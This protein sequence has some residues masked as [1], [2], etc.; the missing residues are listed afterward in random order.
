MESQE[1]GQK[2]SE[3]E[4]E[5]ESKPITLQKW[6]DNEYP[7]KEDKEKCLQITIGWRDEFKSNLPLTEEQVK[8][9]A[10]EELDL[11][12]YPNLKKIQIFGNYL[13]SPL[14]E[15]ELGDKLKLTD[16]VCS[17]NRLSSL[18]LT[19]CPNLKDIQCWESNLVNLKLGELKKLFRL[20]CSDNNLKELDLTNC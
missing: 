11:S 8:K 17:R 4:R 13:K 18:D 5:R 14:T 9:L 1:V 10:G 7:T 2:N 6:L 16:L 20:G 12:E 19:A 15:L 3:L